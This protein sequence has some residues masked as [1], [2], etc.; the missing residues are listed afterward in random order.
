M[1]IAI[2]YVVTFAVFLGLDYFG[3]S[4]I[5]KPTFEKAIGS[6][7]LD[8]LRLGAAIAFYAF[9]VACL[10]WFVSWPAVQADRSLPWV[11]GSAALIGAMAYGTYEFT[12]MATLQ[13]WTW[14][15][16]ATDLTWGTVLT[17]TSA[18]IGVAV[19]RLIGTTAT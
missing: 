12:N 16:V 9:Y 11:F 6:M 13:G 15:M 18:T 4:Y 10:L 7:L 14:R 3:L 17:G 8:D 2:L 19:T 1:T 5:V